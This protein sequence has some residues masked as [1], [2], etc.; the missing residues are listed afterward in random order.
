MDFNNDY[1]KNHKYFILYQSSGIIKNIN[2][3]RD[4]RTYI[5]VL[6][7]H[8]LLSGNYLFHLCLSTFSFGK[9]A[10]MNWSKFSYFD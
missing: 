6:I 2:L 1:I 10:A 7:V 3:I 9:Y 4:P 8:A 5:L